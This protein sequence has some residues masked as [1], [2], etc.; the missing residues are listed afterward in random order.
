[1][2]KLSYSERLVNVVVYNIVGKQIFAKNLDSNKAEVDMSQLEDGIYFLKVYSENG[3][4]TIK[5][6]KN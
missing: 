5:V 1:M 4:R 3:S 6:L 2:L